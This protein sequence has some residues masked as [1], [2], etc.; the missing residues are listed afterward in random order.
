MNELLP[1]VTNRTRFLLGASADCL[2]WNLKP[3]RAQPQ[4]IKH[5]KMEEIHTGRPEKQREGIKKNS[6]ICAF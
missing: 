3:G 6:E 5:R 4:N 2:S 1:L